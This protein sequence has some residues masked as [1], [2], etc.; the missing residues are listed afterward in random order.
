VLSKCGRSAWCS[1]CASGCSRPWYSSQSPFVGKSV[2]GPRI[3]GKRPVPT[4]SGTRVAVFPSV[5]G[6]AR[7]DARERPPTA[8]SA[9]FP[10][11]TQPDP[12]LTNATQSRK[13]KGFLGYTC[14]TRC[15][16]CDGAN[17]VGFALV[18]Q[19]VMSCAL[20][21][22]RETTVKLTRYRQSERQPASQRTHIKCR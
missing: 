1:A 4:R 6:G 10:R 16:V 18:V 9:C 3:T 8:P 20:C 21:S 11:A 15:W 12:Q 14:L 13:T 22:I 19:G 5:R 2:G 17:S 7:P